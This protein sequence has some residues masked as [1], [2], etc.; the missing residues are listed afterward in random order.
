VNAKQIKMPRSPPPVH[1]SHLPVQSQEEWKEGSHPRATNAK[2]KQVAADQGVIRK[3]QEN[4]AKDRR[5]K[6]VQKPKHARK[7]RTETVLLKYIVEGNSFLTS[8]I[9]K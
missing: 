3:A 7:N 2:D 6:R 4:Q 1:P 5:S 8:P 9:A